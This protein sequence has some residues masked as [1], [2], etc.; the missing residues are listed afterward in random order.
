MLSRFWDLVTIPNT[1]LLT[2]IA[3]G[4]WVLFSASRSNRFHAVD[5]LL[6]EQGNASSSRLAVFVAL[7]LSTFM[8]AYV[9]INKT[10]GDETLL[11]M[12][13]AYIL[14]WAGSKT[15]E[16]GLEA[17]TNRPPAQ[18]GGGR[19]DYEDGGYSGMG[20]NSRPMYPRPMPPMGQNR[21]NPP[22][23]TYEDEYGGQHQRINPIAKFTP[24]DM[25]AKEDLSES[26]K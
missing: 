13:G 17:W 5:M 11:Y 24:T 23:V 22:Q 10:V 18:R 1:L 7:S 19:Y 21:F 9:T 3:L 25:P 12:Y 4:V 16:K 26:N 2:L 15:L 8:L 6:D 14:T 20:Y